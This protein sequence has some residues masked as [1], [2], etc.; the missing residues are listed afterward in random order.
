MTRLGRLATAAL[1]ALAT[2]GCA[3]MR[4]AA[5][6]ERN[7][8]FSQFRTWNWGVPDG[9]PTGD[10]RLDNNPMFELQLRSAV[11]H[12]LAGKGYVR[13]PLAGPPDLRARYHVNFSRT[14]EIAGGAASPGSCSRDCEPDAYAYQLG[15]LAVDLVDARTNKVVWSGWSRD[16]MEGVIDNQDRMER[17]IDRVVAAMFERIPSAR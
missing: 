9:L 10:P 2:T 3:T 15:T 17:E 5:H 7:V 13:T 1:L 11:E 14:V 8:N 16:N 6:V 4:V 12:Q